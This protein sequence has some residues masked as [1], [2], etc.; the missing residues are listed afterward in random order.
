M[1]EHIIWQ[2]VDLDYDRDW[3]EYLEDEFPDETEEQR[4]ELM[5]SINNDY[6]DDERANLN[7]DLGE[8][9]LVIGDLG[10]WW[11]R[12]TGCKLIRSGNLSE[13]LYAGRDDEYV[14]WSV[15]RQGDLQ[16]EAHHHDGTNRYLYRVFKPGVSESRIENLMEKIRAGQA[17][18]KD[19]SRL[20]SGLGRT[21]AE[22]YGWSKEEE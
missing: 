9:I 7:I 1:T 15:N 13:C 4:I 16:C 12:T 3:R 8:P 18:R 20:T 5:V 11:G 21:I 10:L 17:T 22:V 6:L 14:K 2:N 19:I